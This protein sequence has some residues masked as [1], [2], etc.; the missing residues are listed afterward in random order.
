MPHYEA[1]LTSKGQVTIPAEVRER[2]A[3]KEGDRVDF[4]VD[5]RSGLVRLMARNATVADL[6]GAL[7]RPEGT[8]APASLE[9]L[10]EAIG[11]HLAEKDEEIKRGWN[12]WHAFQEWRKGR[13]KARKVKAAE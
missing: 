3:L 1:K 7:K 11:A 5:P 2:L 4:Y 10:D 6:V 9:D 12:E 13:N 8:L